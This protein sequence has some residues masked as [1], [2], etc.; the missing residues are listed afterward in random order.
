MNP[1][2]EINLVQTGTAGIDSQSLATVAEQHMMGAKGRG[3]CM[4]WQG[5]DK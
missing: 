3:N 2:N 4:S 1:T 5:G